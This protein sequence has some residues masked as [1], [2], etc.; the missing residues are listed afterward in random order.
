VLGA[1]REIAP[2][3]AA[4]GL[5]S[6]AKEL[7]RGDWPAAP[8]RP[9]LAVARETLLAALQPGVTITARV[10]GRLGEL[11]GWIPPDWFDD[12]LVEPIMAAPTFPRP[13]Y[14]ALDAYD[15]D[16]LIPGL[17]TIR[18]T[19]FVTLLETNEEF[20][21]AFLVGLSHEMGRELLWR[22]YPT[23]QRGSYFR[24]F[25]RQQATDPAQRQAAYDL[26]QQI[27]AFTRAPLG[28]HI[29]ASLQGKL[30]FLI[31]GELIRRYPD[32]IV[33]ALRAGGEDDE[34][35]PEFIDLATDPSAAAPILFHAHLEPDIVLTGFDLKASDVRT[36]P[37]GKGWWFVVAEHPTGP[38]FGLDTSHATEAPWVTRQTLAWIDLAHVQD[39]EP[40]PDAPPLPADLPVRALPDRGHA[41]L[42]AI[43]PAVGPIADTTEA[44][45]PTTIWGR[46]AGGVAHL[47]LQDPVRAAFEGK[48]MLDD[49]G[50][51]P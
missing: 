46:D 27:H 29:A 4:Q 10:A 26:A 41:F 39:P 8:E 14:E 12:H 2:E 33:L 40:P 16:W 1:A 25:W 20:M 24:Q 45:S 51:N 7:V 13:M 28:Q 17:G 19:D 36:A 32:A 11:P 9:P 5:I 15:R 43:D 48:K 21:E 18:E 23:D 22:E 31:R 37:D 42:D 44:G 49:I 35:R 30:V 6:V 38:R 47:L 34:G 50:V 3:S